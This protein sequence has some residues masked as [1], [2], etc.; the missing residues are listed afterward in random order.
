MSPQQL[1]AKKVIK[2][3]WRQ[4]FLVFQLTATGASYL[5]TSDGDN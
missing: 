5:L 3:G 4:S 2:F 1:T